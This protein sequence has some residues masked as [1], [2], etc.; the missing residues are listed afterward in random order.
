[1]DRKFTDIPWCVVFCFFGMCE[2]II[3]FY[4]IGNGNVE[5]ILTAF[6]SDGNPCGSPDQGTENYPFL[7]IDADYVDGQV[8]M[9]TS[10][11]VSTCDVL[12]Y[13]FVDCYLSSDATTSTSNEEGDLRVLQTING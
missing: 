8:V 9:T 3:C 1:M 7:Y 2:L 10:V 11:C 5:R 12:A 6:D 4:A 13:D